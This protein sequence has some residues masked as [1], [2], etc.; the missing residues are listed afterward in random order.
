[1][2]KN[3]PQ[4][5]QQFVLNQPYPPEFQVKG[6]NLV[7][8]PKIIIPTPIQQSSYEKTDSKRSSEEH[9]QTKVTLKNIGNN[10]HN[11]SNMDLS[12]WDEPF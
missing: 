5:K 3:K 4:K 7:A 1:M 8:K 12:P 6:N 10:L 9:L 2:A 11:I